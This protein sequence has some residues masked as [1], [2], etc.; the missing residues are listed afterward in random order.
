MA[1]E[2]S[3]HLQMESVHG[4]IKYKRNMYIKAYIT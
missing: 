3:A 1:V 2:R 4:K